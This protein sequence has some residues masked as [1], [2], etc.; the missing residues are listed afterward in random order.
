MLITVSVWLLVWGNLMIE[1]S[2]DKAK[3]EVA[4]QFLDDLE[5]RHDFLLTELDKLNATVELVL[6]EYTKSRGGTQSASALNAGEEIN[7]GTDQVEDGR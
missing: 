7:I 1:Q 3:R 5:V 6:A 4:L 2:G